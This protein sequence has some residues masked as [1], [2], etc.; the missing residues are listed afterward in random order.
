MSFDPSQEPITV[1]WVRHIVTA[2]NVREE[3]RWQHESNGESHA[4]L[5]PSDRYTDEEILQAQRVVSSAYAY[6]LYD[7]HDQ[8][9]GSIIDYLKFQHDREEK[10]D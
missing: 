4:R 7:L 1:Y 8:I 10:T 9:E 6:A 5:K 3:V 2:D